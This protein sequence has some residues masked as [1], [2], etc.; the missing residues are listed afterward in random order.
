MPAASL[1]VLPD[2]LIDPF[3]IVFYAVGFDN[4]RR[5]AAKLVKSANNKIFVPAL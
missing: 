4:R 2:G 1:D 3:T 5:A